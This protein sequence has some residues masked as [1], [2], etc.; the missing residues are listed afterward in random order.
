MDA[1]L[2]WSQMLGLAAGGGGGGGGGGGAGL[3][4]LAGS[5][6]RRIDVVGSAAKEAGTSS[7]SKRII[8]TGGRARCYGSTIVLLFFGGLPLERQA[9]VACFQ[10]A[11]WFSAVEWPVSVSYPQHNY[12]QIV[13]GP[14]RGQNEIVEIALR[15]CRR[16]HDRDRKLRRRPTTL[17]CELRGGQFVA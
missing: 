17:A 2:S 5:L 12:A 11:R 14:R 16:G 1:V 10:R 4:E 13:L 9:S 3:G 15:K 8:I 7:A 6:R